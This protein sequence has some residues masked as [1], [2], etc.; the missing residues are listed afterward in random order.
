M[1]R[2]KAK[3]KAVLLDRDGTLI[4]DRPGYYLTDPEKLKILKNTPE[5]LKILQNLGF[6]LFIVSNQ[7]AIGRELITERKARAINKKLKDM[8]KNY[9]IKINGIYYCPHR[10]DAKCKC[11]KPETLLGRRIIKRYKLN[12]KLCYMI[13]DKKTDIEFGYNLNMKTVFVKTG[14]GRSELKKYKKIK[15]DF[16]AA[17]ILNAARWVEKNEISY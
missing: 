12:P 14:H 2:K 7:S 13:G 4:Y 1:P 17:N 5:S 15:T 8:L 6:K 9:D 16:S 10:P 3:N 11:R